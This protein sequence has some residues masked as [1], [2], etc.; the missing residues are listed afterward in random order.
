MLTKERT[1]RLLEKSGRIKPREVL[2]AYEQTGLEPCAGWGDGKKYGCAL[3]AMIGGHEGNG[4]TG[5]TTASDRYIQGR[6]PTIS[7]EDASSYRLGF[8]HAF[9]GEC[10]PGAGWFR[11]GYRDGV[12]V[13][14]F[15]FG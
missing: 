1:Q 8:V 6:M 9:D 13:R 7:L 12:R 10:V 5:I 2:A 15:V 11:K 3:T 14:R 4:S